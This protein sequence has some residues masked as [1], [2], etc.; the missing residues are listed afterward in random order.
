MNTTPALPRH[1]TVDLQVNG[2]AGVDFNQDNVSVAQIRQACE[3]M[4]ADGVAAFLGT[5]ITA[6]PEVIARR[7]AQLAEAHEQDD[8]VRSL[9]VGIHIEGPAISP[10]DG[11]RG[12]H[13]LK[14]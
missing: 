10:A 9:M 11:F 13:D 8:L 7:V 6:Q 5:I 2:Y 12:A 3:R 1:G 14:A 4:A